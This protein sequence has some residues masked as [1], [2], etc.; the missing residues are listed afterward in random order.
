MPNFVLEGLDEE[1]NKEIQAEIDRRVTE[2]VKTTTKKVTEEVTASLKA[3]HEEEMLARIEQA[4]LQMAMTD[5][6]RITALTKQIEEQ[7]LQL[8]RSI[9]ERKT[10]KRLLDAG[11]DADQIAALTP[12]IV[13]ASTNETLDETLNTFVTSQQKAIDSALDNQKKQLASGITPPATLGGQQHKQDPNAVFN[14][15][16]TDSSTDPRLAEA[17]AIQYLINQSGN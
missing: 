15:L 5:E 16:L 9:L 17:N 10:E 7:Q 3:T 12:I 14:S 1:Q 2:A 13:K 4:K 8:E 6:E 11:M